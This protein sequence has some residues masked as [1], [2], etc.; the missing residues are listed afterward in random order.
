[1]V[2]AS[3][4]GFGQSWAWGPRKGEATCSFLYQANFINKHFFDTEEVD[5][6]HIRT[7]ALRMDLGYGVTDRLAVGLGLPYVISRYKGATAHQLPIDGGDFHGTFQDYRIDASY[8]AVRSPLAV[9]PFVTAVIPSHD[10]TYF[11][12]SAA[13]HDLH[14]LF[15]GVSVGH[16][17]DRVLPNAYIQSRYYYS[18]VERVLD[19][20]HDRS[21][22]DV[23]FGYFARPKLAFHTL[24]FYQKAH[25]GLSN[26]QV[27]AAS[28]GYALPAMPEKN[29]RVLFFHHDQLEAV[30]YFNVGGGL[31]FTVRGSTNVS[32]TYLRTLWGRM[33]HKLDHSITV[34]VGWRLAGK[35]SSATP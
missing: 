1:M 4:Q 19:I 23:L 25:G 14:E 20:H 13:G 5:D 26:D 28:V 21:N 27:D 8:Q 2:A 32:L 3:P 22:V 29:N 30:D 18:F 12:H 34:G 24:A 15:V 35:R 16:A 7:H 6:G 17:L 10:Y 31:S 33:G 11:A 9:T